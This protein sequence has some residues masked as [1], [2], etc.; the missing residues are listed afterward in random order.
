MF[1]RAVRWPRA[2]RLATASVRRVVGA[3]RVAFEH[4]GQV[5]PHPVEHLAG[6]RRDIVVVL[7]HPFVEAEEDLAGHDRRPDLGVHLGHL[8]GARCGDDV[9]HLHGLDDHQLPTGAHHVAR[10]HA[11]AHHRALEG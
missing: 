6:G 4:L 1:S 11:N 10:G 9:L 5:G 8:A 7:L 2:W 3:D